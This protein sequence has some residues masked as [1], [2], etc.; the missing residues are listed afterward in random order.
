MLAVDLGSP[1]SVEVDGLNFAKE[2]YA[3]GISFLTTLSDVPYGCQGDYVVSLHNSGTQDL[4]ATNVS[5]TATTGKY[6]MGDR[7]EVKIGRIRVYG[8]EITG[9]GST[10]ITT[11]VY[12]SAATVAEAISLSANG[13][14]I[15]IDQWARQLKFQISNTAAQRVSVHKIEVEILNTRKY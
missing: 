11:T 13:T 5:A 15:A 9:T 6:I 12:P 14:D 4:G 10:T 7:L 2:T 1:I 3:S 8:N